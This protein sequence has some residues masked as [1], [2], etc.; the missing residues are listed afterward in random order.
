MRAIEQR[1]QTYAARVFEEIRRILEGKPR[2]KV[3]IQLLVPNRGEGRLC[4][5]LARPAED[6][7]A[8]KPQPHQPGDRGRRDTRTTFKKSCR[9]TRAVPA[10]SRFAIEMG[11]V[12]S[13]PGA[14]LRR[15]LPLGG[16]VRS[17]GATVA[18]T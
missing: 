1:F 16:Q 9:R 17:P 10:T 5:G 15:T 12:W 4:V 8:G 3:L 11:S 7:V 14:R 18:S 6:G 13:P 2:G